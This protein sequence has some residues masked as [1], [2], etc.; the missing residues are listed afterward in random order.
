MTTLLEGLGDERDRAGALVLGHEC[1]GA[2]VAVQGRVPVLATLGRHLLADHLHVEI[3]QGLAK[4]GDVLL[5]LL[6]HLRDLGL[7]GFGA[8]GLHLAG[9]TLGTHQ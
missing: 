5:S 1:L 4:G 8:S 6:A 3:A 9:L 7:D 2:V